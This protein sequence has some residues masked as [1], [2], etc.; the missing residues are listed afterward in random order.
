LSDYV[1]RIDGSFSPNYSA[2]HKDSFLFLADFIGINTGHEFSYVH[3]SMVASQIDG[4]I[5]NDPLTPAQSAKLDVLINC[6]PLVLD[7]LCTIARFQTFDCDATEIKKIT[8]ELKGHLGN[9]V[10]EA[11]ALAKSVLRI[12]TDPGQTDFAPPTNKVVNT[13]S[14]AT[15]NTVYPGYIQ[16]SLHTN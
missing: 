15:Q 12:D 2:S 14:A 5:A 9:R 3:Y 8:N 1:L 16:S 11:L 7:I 13:H 6:D 4:I 10:T